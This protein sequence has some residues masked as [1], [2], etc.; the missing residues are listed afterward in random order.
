MV[1]IKCYESQGP[2]RLARDAGVA[3]STVTRFLR[4]ESSPSIFMVLALLKAIEQQIGREI[5]LR[6]LISLDGTYP[7]QSVCELMGCTGC[8][9]PGA[10]DQDGATRPAYQGMKGGDWSVTPPPA[11]PA[12]KARSGAGT[13]PQP[14][15][16]FGAAAS[17]GETSHPLSYPSVTSRKEE[18]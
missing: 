18:P 1:H 17:R 10:H 5:D 2:G 9:P 8:L 7:T 15:R 16:Q 11:P 13:V 12:G 6:E 4:G 14:D 3:R